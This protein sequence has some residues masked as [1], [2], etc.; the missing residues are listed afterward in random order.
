MESL[1]V[2]CYNHLRHLD[3]SAGSGPGFEAVQVSR[4]SLSFG[5][6][7]PTVFAEKYY[8]NKSRL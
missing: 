3:L 5:K 6:I 2:P 4:L 8:V 1:V 7:S